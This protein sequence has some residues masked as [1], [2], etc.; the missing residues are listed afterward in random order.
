MSRTERASERRFENRPALQRRYL[1]TKRDPPSRRAGMGRR[2][3]FC[4]ARKNREARSLF[5]TKLVIGIIV[6]PDGSPRPSGTGPIWKSS[7]TGAEAPAWN[8]AVY[9]F[10]FPDSAPKARYQNS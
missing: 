3:S 4:L 10:L 1:K 7:V 5:S 9:S 6:R 2:V 8:L